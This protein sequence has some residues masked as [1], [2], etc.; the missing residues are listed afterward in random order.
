MAKLEN[1]GVGRITRREALALGA[2]GAGLGISSMLGGTLVSA[3]T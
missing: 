2:A 1:R 3:Q